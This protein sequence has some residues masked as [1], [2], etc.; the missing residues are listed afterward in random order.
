MD[1]ITIKL[2]SNK[3]QRIAISLRLMDYGKEIIKKAMNLPN[4]E[5][6]INRLKTLL[7]N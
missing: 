1:V 7:N 4:N 3:K 6:A 2:P 5:S